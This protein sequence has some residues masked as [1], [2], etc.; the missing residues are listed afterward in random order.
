MSHQQYFVLN[1]RLQQFCVLV[2]SSDPQAISSIVNE[3]RKTIPTC[4]TKSYG[5]GSWTR[6]VRLN[7]RDYQV[8]ERVVGWLIEGGWQMVTRTVLDAEES[9]YDYTFRRPIAPIAPSSG[10]VPDVGDQLEKLAKLHRS[11]DIND[12]EYAAAKRKLLGT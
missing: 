7:N 1:L 3:I 12:A 11:G 5:D 8:G 9:E 4:D 6:L 10:P 2:K